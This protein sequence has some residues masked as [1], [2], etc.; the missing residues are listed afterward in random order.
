MTPS[1]GGVTA[2]PDGQ[3]AAMGASGSSYLAGLRTTLRSTSAAYGY[4]LTIATTAAE[5]TT[6]QGKPA[7]GDL[8]LFVAG[9]LAAFTILEV[10]LVA[11]QR[12]DGSAPD[13]AFPFAGALNFIS[14]SAGLGAGVAVAHATS[15]SLAWLLSPMAAT[16]AYLLLVAAQVWIVDAM[17]S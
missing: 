6:V 16:A 1:R 12:A 10:L 11:I 3:S 2:A 5:L 17:R 14:V 7:T 4:A 15:A 9:G 8:F 13:D